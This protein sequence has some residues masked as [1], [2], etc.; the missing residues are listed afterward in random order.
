VCG[1]S[2]L[3]HNYN[4]RHDINK[5]LFNTPPLSTSM[6]PTPASSLHSHSRQIPRSR[7]PRNANPYDAAHNWR[8]VVPPPP[9]MQATAPASDPTLDEGDEEEDDTQE[10]N[11]ADIEADD[12]EVADVVDIAEEIDDGN[13]DGE[14]AIEEGERGF[15]QPEQ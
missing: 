3:H 14:G 4:L 10:I 11:D 15:V 9:P 6:S 2:A 7:R 5:P 8:A 12:E 1:P 13:G